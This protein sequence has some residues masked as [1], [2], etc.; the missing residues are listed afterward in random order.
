MSDAGP[1]LQPSLKPR[2][3]SLLGERVVFVGRLA[4]LTPAEAE[5]V[6]RLAAGG[7]MK[8]VT[9]RTTLVVVG[10]LGWPLGKDGGLPAPVAAAE[11]LRAAGRALRL[12]AESVFRGMVGLDGAALAE[13]K[14]LTIDHAA[15]VLGVAADVL[16]RWGELGLVTPSDGCIDFQDLLA[17]R[18]VADLVSRGV[19]PAAIR[20]GLEGLR[21]VVPGVHRPLAQL[22]ILV[23]ASGRLLAE[24]DHALVRPGGQL[25]LKFDAAARAGAGDAG[26]SLALH[27]PDAAACVEL[28]L[29]AERAGDADD[30][31]RHYARAIE[32]DDRSPTPHFNL[33]NVHLAAG[34]LEHAAACYARATALDP[35]HARAHYNLAAA[36]DGLGDPAAAARSLR[37]AVAA[38]PAFADAHYNLADLLERTD[39]PER[40]ARAWEAYLRLDPAGP[41]AEEAR[42]RLALARL[43]QARL[44]QARVGA[45]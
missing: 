35:G 44:A 36:Q 21:G 28:G 8:R 22:T 1:S 27:A 31:A 24:L 38:D 18:T 9:A 10:A 13:P 37:Q 5:R 29:A 33:G 14:P 34:R 20:A 2:P 26:P 39:E 23:G 12:V 42:R 40:A 16:A 45:C 6:V 17:L 7:T 11:R 41:W 30:A 3:A 25:E 32:I 19:H 4:T 15:A 43:E